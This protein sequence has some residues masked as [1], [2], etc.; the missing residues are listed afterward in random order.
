MQQL[1][2]VRNVLLSSFCK[3]QLTDKN[4]KTRLVSTVA[5][6][7]LTGDKRTLWSKY[8]KVINS[9]SKTFVF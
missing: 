4:Q 2:S 7:G 1:L 9:I 3:L 5:A 6:A 8:V